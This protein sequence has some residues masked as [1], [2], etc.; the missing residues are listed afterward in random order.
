M[1]KNII[2]FLI[3]MMILSGCASQSKQP[4]QTSLE[5]NQPEKPVIGLS[6]ELPDR[7]ELPELSGELQKLNE[8]HSPFLYG[9]YDVYNRNWDDPMKIDPNLFVTYYQYLRSHFSELQET[10]TIIQT[11]SGDLVGQESLEQAVTAHLDVSVERIRESNFYDEEKKGYVL[12]GNDRGLI[13]QI[14]SAEQKDNQLVM[15]YQLYASDNIP[16]SFGALIAEVEGDSWK[17][18]SMTSQGYVVNAFEY[19][20]SYG[21]TFQ[22]GIYRIDTRRGVS[23]GENYRIWYG[24]KLDQIVEFYK[25]KL[26]VY[27]AEGTEYQPDGENSWGYYGSYYQGQR[28]WIEVYPKED[29]YQ[30]FYQVEQP[31]TE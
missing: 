25:E 29:G 20:A 12:K 11:D 28:I 17:Y 9:M 1:K 26:E 16:S 7:V 3:T 23:A 13:F 8:Q 4:E 30:I 19:P 15:E 5:L 24:D 21:K 22:N 31:K 10:E 18:R 6:A 14:V 2:C 27:K